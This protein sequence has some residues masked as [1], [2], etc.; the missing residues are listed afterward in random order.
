MTRRANR[1]NIGRTTQCSPEAIINHS[2]QKLVTRYSDGDTGDI[3]ETILEMDRQSHRW[4]RSDAAAQCL[5]GNNE[6]ETLR[7]VWAF[8]KSN[9]RY[10][11]DK[12]G[13]EKVQ[14]P[15]ALFASRVGDC[16]SYSIAE[17]AL[18]RALDIPYRYRFASYGPGD[19]THV[20]I[21]ARTSSG[22][23]PLDAVHTAPLEEARYY[24]KKDIDPQ[25]TAIGALPTP[26]NT[27]MNW[28]NIG[29]LALLIYLVAK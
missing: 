6:D 1:F 13:H 23:K 12:A 18:L 16:K 28:K 8:V 9:V 7:N 29:L 11:A 4:V 10:R 14:S 20:Y 22:L 25:Q 24:R 27:A 5:V 15:G 2:D 21:V 3:I 19:F 26:T 17:A